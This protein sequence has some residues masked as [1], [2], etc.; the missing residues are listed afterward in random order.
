M[1]KVFFYKMIHMKSEVYFLSWK[2]IETNSNPPFP[3]QLQID[4]EFKHYGA[5]V[6]FG[7]F[8]WT[9]IFEV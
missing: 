3:A 8:R 4:F 9:Q 2:K 6:G 7:G 5:R 1:L